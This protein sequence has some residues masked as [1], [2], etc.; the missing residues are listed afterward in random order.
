MEARN[1]HVSPSSRRSNVRQLTH[2]LLVE[3]Y[4]A[5]FGWEPSPHDH[6]LGKYVWAHIFCVL[7]TVVFLDNSTTSLNSK[8]L[9]LFRDFHWIPLYSWEE[10]SLAHLYRSLCRA[11]RYNCKEMDGPLI[12]LFV[13]AW[14]RML[15][16]ASIPRDQIFDVGVPL[17]RQ[18]CLSLL[19]LLF[20]SCCYY[21]THLYHCYYYYCCCCC[22]CCCWSHWRRLNKDIRRSMTQFRR[23]IDDMRVNDVSFNNLCLATYLE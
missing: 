3:N 14:E 11:S 8:F 20:C 12:L 10:T 13:W 2:I 9:P 19:L 22:C 7:E 1:P 4:I 6:V 5:C 21:Y 17:A 15:F 23:Q 18:Y 16:L